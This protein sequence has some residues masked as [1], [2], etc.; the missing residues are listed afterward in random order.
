MNDSHANRS[1][2]NF[3][4]IGLAVTLLALVVLLYSRVAHFDFLNF[5]D[6]VYVTE[7][8]HVNTGLSSENIYWAF[9]EMHAGHWHPLSWLSHQLDVYFFGLDAGKHHLMNVFF[10]V[11]NSLL[12]FFLLYVLFKSP[13]SAF[14]LAACFAL[15]PQRLES[16]V[17]ISER[18]DVLSTF[19]GLSTLHLYVCYTATKRA[20]TL[21]LILAHFF[22]LLGLLAKPSLVVMPLILLLLDYWPLNRLR[23]ISYDTRIIAKHIYEKILF[24]L[25]AGGFAIIVFMAQKNAGAMMT[26]SK[27][28][29]SER[30]SQA[31][32]SLLS[33][34]GKTVWPLGTSLFHPMHPL[35]PG[36]GVGALLVTVTITCFLFKKRHDYK[37]VFFGWCFFIVSLL[38]VIGIIQV[39]AQ[40]MADRWSMWPHIG[41]SIGFAGIMAQN[42]SRIFCGISLIFAAFFFFI[43][44]QEIL[45][46]KNSETIF[47]RALSVDHENF[48]AH[49]NLAQALTLPQQYKKKVF[50]AEE[51]VRLRP[52]Y[53]EA[54]NNLGIIRAEQGLF[55]ESIR[56]FE[57][58]IAINQNFFKARYNLGLALHSRGNFLEALLVWL[59][60]LENTPTDIELQHSLGFL[61]RHQSQAI[62]QSTSLN[63]FVADKSIVRAFELWSSAD[64]EIMRGIDALRECL[65]VKP[66]QE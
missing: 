46:W 44:N 22:F 62:C 34:L 38:P 26:M 33:Y 28:G 61:A 55:D 8:P 53:I 36:S 18:K 11:C 25:L 13:L 12:L 24:F 49:N 60:F 65:K 1:I 63:H 37:A 35:T 29:F 52:Q 27:H 32:L 64:V 3:Q 15:H 59:K 10:H 51:A 17:W 57:R 56:L 31:A 9:S 45:H 16:V 39:G 40:A 54:L 30:I 66:G 4:I 43:S 20:R 47:T 48:L 6:N 14:V 5:D 58:A 2:I 41:L 23:E 7:N 42:H 21:A 50:H 19:F